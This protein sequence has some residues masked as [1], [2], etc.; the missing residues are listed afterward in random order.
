M[1]L[2]SDNMTSIL[3]DFDFLLVIFPFFCYQR[4]QKVNPFHSFNKKRLFMQ[5]STYT[6]YPFYITVQL[7]SSTTTSS[8][9]YYATSFSDGTLF[10]SNHNLK[11]ILPRAIF[12]RAKLT[13]IENNKKKKKKKWKRNLFPQFFQLL[14]SKQQRRIKASAAL[15]G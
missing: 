4:F 8:V 13:D 6:V 1:H 12:T 15:C 9:R 7:H 3:M 11:Q 14:Y 5:R 2:L 10:P